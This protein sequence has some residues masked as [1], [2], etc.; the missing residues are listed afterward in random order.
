MTNNQATGQ[1]NM[2]LQP[3]TPIGSILD[4]IGAQV[5]YSFVGGTGPTTLNSPFTEQNVG[6][7]L[8]QLMDYVTV[9]PAATVPGRINVNQA[10]PTVLSGIPGMTSDIVSKITAQR[11][12]DMT[13]ADP[14]RR[15]ETW[16]LTE[17]VVTLPQMK[18][19]MPFI[20][21]G[22]SVYRCQVVGYFQG[23]QASSRAEVVFDATSP[24]PRIVL[25]RD[26]THLGRGYTLDTLGLNYSK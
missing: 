1:L 12:V 6:N 25:W 13:S 22:G 17:G 18:V 21:G 19:L 9:N 20:T 15:Y 8:P 24:L 11:T 3:K 7:Y 2:D 10:S 4:L 16:L 14:A 26:L 23:G 5:Q